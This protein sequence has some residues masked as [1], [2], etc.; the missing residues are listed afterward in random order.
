ML[1]RCDA[2]FGIGDRYC[3]LPDRA[4]IRDTLRRCPRQSRQNMAATR[5]EQWR[6]TALNGPLRIGACRGVGEA[7][8]AGPWRPVPPDRACRSAAGLSAERPGMPWP[9]VTGAAHEGVPLA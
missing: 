6:G 9:S 5:C 3:S 7:L 8:A 4:L 2:L 1:T